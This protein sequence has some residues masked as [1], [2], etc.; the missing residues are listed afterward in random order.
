[1]IKDKL[2]NAKTYYGLSENFKVGLEWIKNNDLNNLEDGKYSI[3]GD[4][5]YA[6]IQTYETKDKAPFEAHKKYADI[7]YLVHGSEKIGI[8]DYS[9][10][11]ITEPYNTERDVEFLQCKNGEY[12]T[13]EEGEFVIFFPQDA[14]Q[15]T[16]QNIRKQVVKKIVVKVGL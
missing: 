14:H 6:K 8:A 3:K 4:E 10:C 13:I 15:P 16:L 5:I 9:D 2:K 7:Q 1:M 12:T 11:E